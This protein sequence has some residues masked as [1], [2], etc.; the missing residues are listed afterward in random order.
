MNRHTRNFPPRILILDIAH[1]TR[2]EV[3]LELVDA[4]VDWGD[5]PSAFYMLAEG[6][7]PHRSE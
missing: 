4:E 3:N 1:P 6:V 2:N 5:L 7:R